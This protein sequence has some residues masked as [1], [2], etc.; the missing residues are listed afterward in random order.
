[1]RGRGRT[2]RPA[3]ILAESVAHGHGPNCS[4]I[5]KMVDYSLH[6]GRYTLQIAANSEERL[7]LLVTP[8]P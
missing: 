3:R 8:S 4:G 1:M 6:P 2:A 5:R 7:T